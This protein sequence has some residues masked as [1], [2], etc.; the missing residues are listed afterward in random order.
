MVHD[1]SKQFFS[2]VLLLSEGPNAYVWTPQKGS[3][4]VDHAKFSRAPEWNL[5][6]VFKNLTGVDASADKQ[7]SSGLRDALKEMPGFD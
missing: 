4:V 3:E 1:A 6:S 2:A 5:F 7:L